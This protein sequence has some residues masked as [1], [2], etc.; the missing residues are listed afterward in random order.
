MD[1]LVTD[2]A[3]GQRRGP[4]Q[5]MRKGPRARKRKKARAPGRLQAAG[6]RR[7]PASV[8]V[9]RLGPAT[10]TIHRPGRPTPPGCRPDV[11]VPDQALTLSMA[12]ALN[13]LG[14][15]EDAGQA[16]AASL[17][18]ATGRPSHRA[19]MAFETSRG[20]RWRPSPPTA[21]APPRGFPEAPGRRL[22]VKPRMAA[23]VPVAATAARATVCPARCRWARHGGPCR[24]QRER[25]ARSRAGDARHRR[26]PPGPRSEAGREAPNCGRSPATGSAEQ[27]GAR[28]QRH[29][30]RV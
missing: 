30:H 19:R 28:P 6:R 1:G 15:R 21:R 24:P 20:S 17:Q 4:V 10:E 25:A 3:Q 26:P 7:H 22:E 14:R 29:R 9:R 23:L 8:L 12:A 11:Q 13:G 16:E 5:A 18:P 27:R 2:R